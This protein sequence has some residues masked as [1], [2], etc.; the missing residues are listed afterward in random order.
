MAQCIIERAHTKRELGPARRFDGLADSGCC[1]NIIV[2]RRRVS[3]GGHMVGNQCNDRQCA[4]GRRLRRW[5]RPRRSGPGTQFRA[6]EGAACGGGVGP[7]VDRGSRCGDGPAAGASSGAAAGDA[8][9]GPAFRSVWGFRGQAGVPLRCE[10]MSSSIL[11]AACMHGRVH[12]IVASHIFV[13][14][15]RSDFQWW[16]A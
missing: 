8:P 15:S 5:R 1:N 9:S 4:R 14:F 12:D 16:Y 13:F 2:I 6:L 11:I 3:L 10:I 7:A